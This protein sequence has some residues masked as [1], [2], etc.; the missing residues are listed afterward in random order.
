MAVDACPEAEKD[1][2][3]VQQ[4]RIVVG[5]RVRPFLPGEQNAPANQG[6]VVLSLIGGP[7]RLKHPA[8]KEEKAW[9][10]FDYVFNSEPSLTA[11][12]SQPSGVT[13]Q[14]TV[15]ETFGSGVADLMC[16]GKSC[17]VFTYGQSNTGKTYTMYGGGDA[18][19]EGLAPRLCQQI[20]RR[21]P[22]GAGSVIDVALY[23]LQGEKV[24][25]LMDEANGSQDLRVR[26]HKEEG[27]YV[28]GL[29]C[30]TVTNPAL[31]SSVMSLARRRRT[32]NA[33][34]L[35]QV[36]IVWGSDYRAPPRPSAVDGCG[37]IPPKDW[38]SVLRGAKKTKLVH[39]LRAPADGSRALPSAT[40]TLCDLAGT[41]H[42]SPLARPRM[43][44]RLMASRV[45]Q[46][47]ST[48]SRVMSALSEDAGQRSLLP[49]RESL[50]TWLLKDKLAGSC[51][52]YVIA[53]VSPCAQ[54][55]ESTLSTLL[56]A[57]RAR[58][59]VV[60]HREQLPPFPVFAETG[61]GRIQD[62]V[63]RIDALRKERQGLAVTLEHLQQNEGDGKPMPPLSRRPS[64]SGVGRRGSTSAERNS[65][66]QRIGRR[67][68][69]PAVGFGAAV[70][71][72]RRHR[73]GSASR[74]KSLDDSVTAPTPEQ[75]RDRLV[76][77][78]VQLQESRHELMAEIERLSGTQICCG[79]AF[80]SDD[81]I[82]FSK[83]PA[84][85]TANS[86]SGEGVRWR[87]GL[88]YPSVILGH[89]D[90]FVLPHSITQQLGSLSG[91]LFSELEAVG[92]GVRTKAEEGEE[93]EEEESLAEVVQ[94]EDAEAGCGEGTESEERRKAREALLRLEAE[95][96]EAEAAE[97]HSPEGVKRKRNREKQK[98]VYR[99]LLSGDSLDPSEARARAVKRARSTLSRRWQK[100]F[101][102]M[103]GEVEVDPD[104]YDG[105]S[106]DVRSWSSVA[107]AC[108]AAQDG[109]VVLLAPGKYREHVVVP[110]SFAVRGAGGK[111]EIEWRGSEPAV[112]LCGALS[113]LRGVSVRK[114]GGDAAVHI[115]AG[116]PSLMN[117]KVHS[118]S[119]EC[120]IL[121][122]GGTPLVSDCRISG[123]RTGL[124][125]RGAG[126]G[127]VSGCTIT[128]CGGCAIVVEGHSARPLVEECSLVGG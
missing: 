39:K 107:D 54:D 123:L 48:L 84:D 5:V 63:Q 101:L 28:D 87:P 118:D 65:G 9:D 88:G 32:T 93:V 119:A 109:E 111:C 30:L 115:A 113:E 20:L 33:H 66:L 44:T 56:F 85:A 78:D 57:E 86:E 27:P 82:L 71:A 120:G 18:E 3:A 19:H 73:P 42:F 91:V 47:L 112:L 36:R 105:K 83:L 37:T 126:G 94:E 81:G 1:S 72:E 55:Y 104:G 96:R 14:E 98:L 79:A 68:S 59:V 61:A 116:S 117:C 21:S 10:G 35:L 12:T 26:E 23:E 25:D 53:T 95:G 13:T 43:E 125:V 46:S 108:G 99:S 75:L 77:I 4:N 103:V 58:K 6:K 41:T 16:S 128:E 50:L 106:W 80:T 89:G 29:T 51:R 31:L 7:L 38:G 124:W 90:N 122:S 76:F 17:C 11:D 60:R 64:S 92:L 69:A 110:R 40:L 22:P 62:I 2:K 97:E 70:A 34:H 74:R 52:S 102:H 121:V 24:V 8:L 100:P 127:V 114:M 45:N 49:H 67:G 15:Y